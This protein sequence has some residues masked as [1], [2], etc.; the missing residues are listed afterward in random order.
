MGG[1]SSGFASR[2]TTPVD[3]SIATEKYRSDGEE[4]GREDEVDESL[5]T[6]PSVAHASSTPRVPATATKSISKAKAATA[7]FADYPSPYENLKRELQGSS[8]PAAAPPTSTAVPMETT[9]PGKAQASALPDMSMTPS[10][11]PF[12]IPPSA[13]QQHQYDNGRKPNND[14]LMHRVLDKNYRIAATPHTARKTQVFSKTGAT[15]GTSTRTG[16]ARFLDS[17]PMSSPEVPAPQLRA[18]LF[19]PAKTRMPGVSVQH[20]PGIKRRTRKSATGM[21]DQADTKDVF[22]GRTATRTRVWDSDSEDETNDLGFS[23]PKTMQF[24]IPQSRILQTPGMCDFLHMFHLST[25]NTQHAR[26]QS[27][28]WKICFLQPAEISQTSLT[29]TMGLET[30]TARAW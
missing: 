21:E 16:A 5:L 14:I 25:N 24:H 3:D 7:T 28:S 4:D 26:H 8:S 19:S 13:T 27:V 2:T 15:P 11:S 10:S 17:S 18:D 6:S 9:T 1:A 12:A 22:G 29:I 20:T 23:P 30:M